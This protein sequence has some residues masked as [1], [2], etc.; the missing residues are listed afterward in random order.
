MSSW[1]DAGQPC[2]HE[3]SCKRLPIFSCLGG[4]ASEKQ[5]SL[6]RATSTGQPA[7]PTS[8]TTPAYVRDTSAAS[9]DVAA[10]MLP[11]SAC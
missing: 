8:V 6:A 11:Q 7:Q 3:P 2:Q 9:Q 1:V 10:A 4:R 5:Y